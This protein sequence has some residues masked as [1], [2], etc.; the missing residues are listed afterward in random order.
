MALD[1]T[2]VIKS[3]SAN[4]NSLPSQIS[5][6]NLPHSSNDKTLARIAKIPRNRSKTG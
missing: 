6:S 4:I 3:V 2:F 5:E 1:S